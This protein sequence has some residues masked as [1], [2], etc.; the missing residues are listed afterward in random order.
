MQLEPHKLYV[1]TKLDLFSRPPAPGVF[2]GLHCPQDLARPLFSSS[3]KA[4]WPRGAGGPAT[5]QAQGW[6]GSRALAFLLWLVWAVLLFLQLWQVGSGSP[7]RLR[8]LSPY[9]QKCPHC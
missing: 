1:G 8:L 6:P 3:G 4:A 5:V 2:A 7:A 9:P